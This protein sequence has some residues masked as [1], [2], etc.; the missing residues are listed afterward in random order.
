[1]PLVPANVEVFTLFV[2]NIAESRAFYTLVFDP[3]IVYED[4]QSIVFNFG[5]L[6]INL[7]ATSEAHDLVA[8]DPISDP[9]TG[10]SVLPTI[11]VD[12]IDS[13]CA[14]LVQHGISLLN[15]PI[16]RPWGRRTATFKDPSG[17]V[18]ELAQ[19]LN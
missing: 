14:G 19:V 7:L 18:W 4:A 15:G 9:S 10:P 6:W 16:D 8:P 11:R 3:E 5:S 17:H 12:D 2:N 1:M 13:V